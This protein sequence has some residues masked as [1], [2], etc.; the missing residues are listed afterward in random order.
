MRLAL[1]TNMEVVDAAQ[2]GDAAIHVISRLMPD[3][4]IMDLEM[5]IMDGLAATKMLKSSA[6]KTQVIILTICD[7][8]TSSQRVHEAGAARFVSKHADEA[9]LLNAIRSLANRSRQH[10]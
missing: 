9:A 10:N 2:N 8:G 7:D 5:P 1:E 6:P 3:I 4:V